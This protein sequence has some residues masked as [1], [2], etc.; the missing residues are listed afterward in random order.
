MWPFARQISYVV[1]SSAGA[2]Q[3][4]R[5]GLTGPDLAQPHSEFAQLRAAVA[6]AIALLKDVAPGEIDDAATRDVTFEFGSGRME[7]VAEDFLLSFSLPNFFFHAVTAYSILRN[8]GVEV[9]KRDF[10]GRV[11]VRQ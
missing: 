6:D 9:G 10:L 1:L 3:A 4:L 2:V 7:Y 8:Q 5:T 11:R